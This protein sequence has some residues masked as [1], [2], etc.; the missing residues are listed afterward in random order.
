MGK[1]QSS[2]DIDLLRR[3]WAAG[4]TCEVIAAALGCPISYVWDLRDRYGLPS[5][6]KQKPD[7]SVDPTPEQI[8]ERAAECRRRREEKIL[9]PREAYRAGIKTFS[10]RGDRF[11]AIA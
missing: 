2:Y 11:E 4:E 6:R 3:L 10:W 1:R 5:R 7:G 9:P 8:A